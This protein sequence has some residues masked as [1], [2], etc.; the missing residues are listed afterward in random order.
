MSDILG[1]HAG[2][3][4]LFDNGWLHLFALDEAGRMAWRYAGDLKWS[5]AGDPDAAHASQPLEM[6]V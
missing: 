3:R 1:R 2:V 4:A 5:M 6:A